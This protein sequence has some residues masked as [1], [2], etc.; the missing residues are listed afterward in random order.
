MSAAALDLIPTCVVG[1]DEGRFPDVAIV[2]EDNEDGLFAVVVLVPLGEA[3]VASVVQLTMSRL[4]HH[5]QPCIRTQ[6]TPCSVLTLA[7]DITSVICD[8]LA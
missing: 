6:K 4:S 8:F 2:G 5:Q 3:D 7:S 1:G